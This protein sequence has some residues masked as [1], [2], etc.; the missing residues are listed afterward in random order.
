MP[1]VTFIHGIANK[2]DES[3]LRKSWLDALKND[4]LGH[5][6]VIDLGALGITSSMIYW[7]DVLYSEPEIE[8]VAEGVTASEAFSVM[9][10]GEAGGEW[11][12][13][14][15][16]EERVIVDALEAALLS[17]MPKDAG[18][19]IDLA[20]SRDSAE[21]IWLPWFVKSRLMNWLLRDVHHYLFNTAYNPRAGETYRVQE[22]IRRRVIAKLSEVKTDRHIVVSHSMGTVIMYDCLK[23]VPE[24]P[25][26]DG[27]MTIGSPLGLDEIQDKLAPEWTRKNGFP[28]KVKGNWVNVYDRLDPVAGFD[29]DLANDYKKEGNKV[30]QVIR[31]QNWGDWRHDITKYLSGPLLRDALKEMLEIKKM[32]MSPDEYLASLRKLLAAY[33]INEAK[34]LVSTLI[35]RLLETEDDFG[36][37]VPGKIMQLLRNK[38]QFEL[39]QQLGEA[40][41]QTGRQSANIKRQYA[42]ALIEQSNLT[43]AIAVLNELEKETSGTTAGHKE[44]IEAKGLL[45]RAYK[46]RFVNAANPG[47]K[48]NAASLNASFGYYYQ[49]YELKPDEYTWHGI[50]AVALLKRADADGLAIPGGHQANELA[51][52]ILQTIV[53]KHDDQLA[54]AWDF[55]T[56]AE[57]CIALGRDEE[58]LRWMSGY[59]RMPAC[60]AF[61]LASTMRQLTEVWRL[62]LSSETGKLL[63]PL[64]RAELLKR[65]GGNIT[66][67]LREVR[68]MLDANTKTVALY[69]A[70]IGEQQGTIGQVKLEKVFGQDSFS[71]YN[72]M[73]TG[74]SR[75]LPVARVGVEIAKGQGTGFLIRGS[76]MH[77]SL[78]DE[79]VLLTNAHV[80]SA[81]PEDK[82]IRPEEAVIV[83]EVLD[84]GHG[85]KVETILWH[86]PK[87]Q[88]D[89]TLVRFNEKDQE[90]L[91]ALAGKLE[92]YPLLPILPVIDADNIQRIYIIGHPAGGIIQYS[93]HDNVLLDHKDPLIH[94]RTPTAEG[95]S[96]SPVFDQQWHLIGLHRAGSRVMARLNGEPGDYEA[97]E[98]VW[99]QSIRKK[100]SEEL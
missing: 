14:L 41:M 59:A 56:A 8:A 100:M 28:E 55:A 12:D 89:A 42:Q 91:A 31:E 82:A 32:M 45:G 40:L 46:Q 77:D 63:L 38:R 60:D 24:C 96:G 23:R 92:V 84:P 57:A 27:L 37:L 79:L 73:M 74:I 70:A 5:N 97:N 62:D 72:W 7:A 87:T 10:D 43:A 50:N 61:E 85:Y 21:R 34:R 67:N 75:A 35:S 36:D 54:T 18:T 71:S 3:S 58:A 95:S 93:I 80:L 83:F 66:I 19:A 53:G 88:L 44:Q 69:E 11:R 94:Y 26:I 49:V 6:D 52:N 47:S 68:Q 2:P 65:E 48:H 30:V 22:E 78:G 15:Q 13:G 1:H 86:S 39:M 25:P 29:G 20:A 76:V 17:G 98:G 51:E 4:L 99:I 81:D 33:D 16:G 64:L 9:Q 90:R